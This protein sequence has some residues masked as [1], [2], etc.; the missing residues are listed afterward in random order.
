MIGTIKPHFTYQYEE[1]NDI[2]YT[3]ANSRKI[4]PKE[5]Y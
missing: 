2:F 4:I 5:L 3:A 1:M